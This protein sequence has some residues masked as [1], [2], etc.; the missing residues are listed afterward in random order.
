MADQE[1]K[2]DGKVLVDKAALSQLLERVK[3]LEQG[4]APVLQRVKE[5]IVRLRR[6][7]D[8]YVVGFT[9]P[10]QKKDKDTGK[11]ETYWDI[12]L[13]T[14]EEGAKPVKKTVVYTEFLNKAERVEC[15]IVE[16]K[17]SIHEELQGYV[18]VKRVEG[19]KTIN[20]GVKVPVLITTPA[21]EF[22]VTLPDGRNV[23]VDQKVANL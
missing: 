1:I 13:S 15:K 10:Y 6:V 4:E 8:K 23:T 16:R 12:L 7:E 9:D 20:T 5:H 21:Y 14:L 18:E 2:D 17:V 22:V 19:F 11:S 3:R